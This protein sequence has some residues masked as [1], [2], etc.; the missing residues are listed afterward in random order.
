MIIDNLRINFNL[1]LNYNNTK[2]I[3]IQKSKIITLKAISTYFSKT[4]EAMP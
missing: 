2:E 1:N 3:K 4:L